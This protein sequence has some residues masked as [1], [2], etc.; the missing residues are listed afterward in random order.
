MSELTVKNLILK[1]VSQLSIEQL[2]EVLTHC[3]EQYRKGTP[4]ISDD[5]F[6]FKFLAELKKREPH[7]KFLNKPQPVSFETTETGKVIHN[8]RMLSTSKVYSQEETEKWV[9]RCTKAAINI[10]IDPSSLV[11]RCTAKLDGI[12]GKLL[13]GNTI[14]T[15]G[16]DGVHGND[17]SSQFLENGLVVLGDIQHE[18]VGE[19]VIDQKY[20]NDNL[21]TFFADSRSAVA[22]IANSD[23]VNKHMIKAMKDGAI[24][25]V[26][27]KSMAAIT[28][29]AD[30]LI[31]T[32]ND[33]E[34][35][36]RDGCDYQTDG[37]VIEVTN[38]ELKKAM[39]SN[40]HD[41]NWQTAKKTRGATAFPMVTKVALQV[42]RSGIVTPVAIFAPI[43][44]GNV[45]ISKA[46]CHNIRT[47]LDLGI[48][49]GTTLE[50]ERA[51]DV[52][53]NIVSVIHRAETVEPMTCPCCEFPLVWDIA[54]KTKKDE[55]PA[56][57]SCQ[58]P[59]CPAQAV[60]TISSHFK[61]LK[62]LGFGTKRVETLVDAG[63]TTFPQFYGLTIEDI[64]ACGIGKGIAANMVSAIEKAKAYA[65]SDVALLASV[66]IVAIEKGRAKKLLPHHSLEEIAS[67]GI[68]SE[69]LRL[70]DGFGNVLSESCS[71][72][73]NLQRENI[74]FLL[75]TFI[76]VTSQNASPS[77]GNNNDLVEE[78]ASITESPVANKNIVFTG[79]MEQGTREE[80][81]DLAE[82]MGAK[83]QKKVNGKTDFLVYGAKAGA[84][85]LKSAT[86]IG[87]KTITEADYLLMIA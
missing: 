61:T 22:G 15:R 29:N 49:V 80:M 85:K 81:S 72:L 11:Y 86:D 35:E 19:I 34:K 16:D 64:V 33:I 47:M 18:S 50:I 52:I 3:N 74:N 62:I 66:G 68:S 79:T 30:S 48:N 37:I 6:D 87:V 57:K 38:E 44:V 5:E 46:T 60:R 39:G 27:Y 32:I 24:H 7:H 2:V 1:P 21:S 41:H 23:T 40:S 53:P 77:I 13:N 10:G 82:K 65:V 76:N 8:V 78:N 54:A 9:Q 17:V 69:Q 31:E 28:V 67:I 84:S 63:Y 26:I 58:N 4:V 12:A 73:L 56:T 20:Y 36:I 75:N 59:S 45:M 55:L 83:V 25:F 51:G 71:D 14:V 42:G 70:I 43:K